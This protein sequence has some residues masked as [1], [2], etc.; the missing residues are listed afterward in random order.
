MILRSRLILSCRLD[1]FKSEAYSAGYNDVLPASTE[2]DEIAFRVLNQ[3]RQMRYRQSMQTV[4]RESRHAITSDNLTGLF[5]RGFLQAHLEAQLLAEEKADRPLAIAYLQL[6]TLASVNRL[7]GFA[8]GD[9][10]LRQV[11]GMIGNLVRGEDLAARHRGDCFVIV[12]PGTTLADAHVVTGRITGVI[13]ASSF[14]LPD[15]EETTSVHLSVACSERRMG[16]TPDA[17][18]RR[19][20]RELMG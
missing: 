2:P 14:A 12:M 4:Y 19:V 11:G 13:N 8:A 16:D 1:G 15:V 7:H 17:L 10:L 5:T 6:D 9:Q 3:V 20:R 18:L